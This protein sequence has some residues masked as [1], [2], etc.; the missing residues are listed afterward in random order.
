MAVDNLKD[1]SI[2]WIL[3]GLLLFCLL[4]FTVIFIYANAD[5]TTIA[6]L[7]QFEEIQSNFSTSL[8]QVENS[9][10]ALLNITAQTDP[11]QG[12]LGSRDSVATSYGILGTAKTFFTSTKVFMSWVLG[13]IIGQVLMAIF[14]GMFGLIA[15]YYITKWVRNG[16]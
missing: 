15:L 4:N 13:G 2:E 12:Y 10:D 8:L 1:F 7:D 11:E 6:G 3:V 16:V 5:P 14:G 9:T